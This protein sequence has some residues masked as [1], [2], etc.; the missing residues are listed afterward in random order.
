[1]IL[2]PA[3]FITFVG[4]LETVLSCCSR[5]PFLLSLRTAVNRLHCFSGYR[6]RWTANFDDLQRVRIVYQN[7]NILP[8]TYKRLIGHIAHL[9]KIFFICFQYHFIKIAIISPCRRAWLLIWKKNLNFLYLRMLY[10]KF[11][12]NWPC[13]SEV[14]NF[15][16]IIHILLFF[17]IISP[18]GGVWALIYKKNWIIYTQGCF[19][20]N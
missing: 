12:W 17:A 2:E 7:L 19:V 14:K 13:S 11:G 16:N 1:M 5:L 8:W 18:W 6:T 3:R 15:K 10:A 9:R 4:M 20:P